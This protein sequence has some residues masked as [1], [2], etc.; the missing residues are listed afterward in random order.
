MLESG[1]ELLLLH[2]ETWVSYCLYRDLEESRYP[3]GHR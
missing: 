1:L 2:K 3:L